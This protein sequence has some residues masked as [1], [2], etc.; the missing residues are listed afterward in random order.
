[1]TE[2][3]VVIPDFNGEKAY[4][5]AKEAEDVQRRFQ[6]VKVHAWIKVVAISTPLI[7]K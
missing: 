3:R 7:T 1:M 6:K 4:G 5:S 2:Y